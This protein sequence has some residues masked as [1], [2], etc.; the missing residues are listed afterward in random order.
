MINNVVRGLVSANE[1]GQRVA[2]K[3][4]TIGLTWR[5]SKDINLATIKTS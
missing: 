5:L 4:S 1:C 3:R 2:L